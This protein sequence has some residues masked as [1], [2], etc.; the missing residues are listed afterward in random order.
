MGKTYRVLKEHAELLRQIGLPVHAQ[1]I[2]R[3]AEEHLRLCLKLL[4]TTDPGLH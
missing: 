1:D 3:L 4:E 2:E